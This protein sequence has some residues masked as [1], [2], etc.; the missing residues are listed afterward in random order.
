[1]RHG[2]HCFVIDAGW[3]INAMVQGLGEDVDLLTQCEFCE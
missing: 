1:M 3:K 2:Y